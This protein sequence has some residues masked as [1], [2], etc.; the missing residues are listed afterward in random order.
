MENRRQFLKLVGWTGIGAWAS[1]YVG[2]N[3]SAAAPAAWPEKV[4]DL[5]IHTDRPPNLETP[6]R[7]FRKDITPT[8]AFFVRWHLSNLPTTVDLRK[9][10]LEVGG[11]VDHPLALSIDDLRA[12]F[13]A[14]SL[15]AV[16]Q[17]AGNSRGLFDPHVPGVQVPG[18]AMGN[19]RWKGARLKDI[20]AKAGMRAGA[21]SVSFAG[22]DTAPVPSVPPFIKALEPAHAT[23]GEVMVAYEMNDA[24]LPMLNGFPL[25]LVVPG[26]YST[27]WVKALTKIDVLPAAFD[28]YWMQK[29]YRIP[30]TADANED[31]KSLAPETVPIHRLNVRSF[32][33]RP[34]PGESLRAGQAYDVEGIAFDGGSGIDKVEVST[35]GGA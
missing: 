26:W 22:L 27:Y 16:N 3:A 1:G 5:L 17:C 11:Q 28:G 34:E 23:D 14:V 25:R 12:Q 6:L 2:R 10:R 8:D 15:V 9:F 32:V 4:S 20:L 13:E 30:K 29:A 18:G 33:I 35:D 19:G 24:P 21:A 31:P 7:Y